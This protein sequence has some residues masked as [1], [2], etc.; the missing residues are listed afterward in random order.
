MYNIM[1][2]NLG[3]KPRPMTPFEAILPIPEPEPEDKPIPPFMLGLA[4]LREVRTAEKLAS[5]KAVYEFMC[6]KESTTVD[7]ITKHFGWSDDKTRKI[8]A[9]LKKDRRAFNTK[10]DGSLVH[11][12]KAIRET[13]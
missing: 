4:R 1:L 10:I 8:I 3:L 11:I 9:T 13:V 2:M 6:S 7:E 5:I 12:W